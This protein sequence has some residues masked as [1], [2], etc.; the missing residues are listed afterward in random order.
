[1][2]RLQ[3]MPC[4][5]KRSGSP[6]A[7]TTHWSRRGSWPGQAIVSRIASSLDSSPR[8]VDGLARREQGGQLRRVILRPHSANGSVR[9][10]RSIDHS[11]APCLWHYSTTGP[12]RAVANLV[13]RSYLLGDDVFVYS[14]LFNP[15]VAFADDGI[16]ARRWHG[17]IAVHH[18]VPRCV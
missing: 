15:G 13:P 9:L 16:L 17:D 1:M 14:Y 12:D 2:A 6:G 18:S 5:I 8:P 11:R 3:T 10:A 4:A 7:S